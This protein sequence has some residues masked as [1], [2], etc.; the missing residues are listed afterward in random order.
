MVRD[1]LELEELTELPRRL[2]TTSFFSPVIV[3]NPQ[4]AIAVN[5]LNLGGSQAAV[6]GNISALGIHL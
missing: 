4:I 2:E 6:G 3:V 1:E 5:G